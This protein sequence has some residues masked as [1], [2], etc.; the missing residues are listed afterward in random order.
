MIIQGLIHSMY[1]SAGK[2]KRVY[3]HDNLSQEWLLFVSCIGLCILA[4]F[5]VQ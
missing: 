4:W 1:E 5:Y 2:S 3:T